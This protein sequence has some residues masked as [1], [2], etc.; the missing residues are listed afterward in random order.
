MQQ[1]RRPRP[2]QFPFALGVRLD[3]RVN[4]ALRESARERGLSPTVL[5]RDLIARGLDILDREQPIR[6]RT[7][8]VRD[9]AA[10]RSVLQLL[11]EIGGNLQRTCTTL[12]VGGCVDAELARLKT[13]LR[14]IA[15]HLR[16]ALRAGPP[17]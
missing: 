17:A 14:E 8:A 2:I 13:D 6:R 1:K 9:E 5:A 15:N 10:I 16:A 3:H 11:G 12:A 4:D 7:S